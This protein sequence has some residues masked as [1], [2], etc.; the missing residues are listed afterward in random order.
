MTIIGQISLSTTADIEMS[1]SSK[2]YKTK[3]NPLNINIA[4]VRL[5]NS[6]FMSNLWNDTF[7]LLGEIAKIQQNKWIKNINIM[8]GEKYER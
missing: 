3:K 4:I 2:L 5:L 7:T 6:H 8:L 1:K